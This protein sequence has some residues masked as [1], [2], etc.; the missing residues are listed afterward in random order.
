MCYGGTTLDIKGATQTT[1]GAR[2]TVPKRHDAAIR[3][4]ALTLHIGALPQACKDE[5]VGL[6]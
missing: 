5:L 6:R 3:H 1:S 4:V 2:A